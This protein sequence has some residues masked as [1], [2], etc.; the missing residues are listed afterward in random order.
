MRANTP[1]KFAPQ[2]S[3]KPAFDFGDISDLVGA[4]GQNEKRLLG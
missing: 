1:E 2:G 4:L 3:K